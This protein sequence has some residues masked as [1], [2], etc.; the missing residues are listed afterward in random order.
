[1]S[2]FINNNDEIC[3][4]VYSYKNNK[5]KRFY[6][7]KNI[8]DKK[9]EGITEDSAGVTCNKIYFRVPTYKDNLDLIDASIKVEIDG[10]FNFSA[11][12]LS[13]GRFVNLLK[14]WDFVNTDGQKIPANETS[15]SC[16]DNNLAQVIMKDL[17]S[18]LAE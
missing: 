15:V 1:M 17:E 10:K 13:Y 6:W 14:D 2:F 16:I 12:K 11:S 9:P 5:N 7:T 4:V 8:I 18:Q 3:V